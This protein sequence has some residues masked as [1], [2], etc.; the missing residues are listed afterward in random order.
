[1][2]KGLFKIKIDMDNECLFKKQANN[3]TELVNFLEI[4]KKKFG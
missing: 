2:K 4:I 3:N 1:M